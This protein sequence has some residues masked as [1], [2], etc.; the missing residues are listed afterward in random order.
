MLHSKMKAKQR[1][2]TL[3]EMM[4][5]I[6]LLAAL[7]SFGLPNFRDFVRNARMAAAANDLLADMNLAR[8]EAIKRRVPVTLCK[9]N[10][11]GDDCDDDDD[12][13]FRRWIVYVDDADA[14]VDESADGDGVVDAGEAILRTSGIAAEIDDAVA[15]G[16]LST[17]ISS[18]FILPNVDNLQQVVFCD[19]R[20]N[21][22]TSGGDSAARAITITATGRAVLTRNITTIED[23]LGGCP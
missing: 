17:F 2:F 10:A 4:V 22:V 16:R 8:S 12:T 5:A 9:L 7:L 23:T 19:S 3:L 20:G 13:P 1:G 15:T 6:G 14:A 18:G 21:T 11:D